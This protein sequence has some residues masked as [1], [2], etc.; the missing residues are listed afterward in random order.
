MKDKFNW[1]ENSSADE[2]ENILLSA[3]NVKEV[4]IASA[5][6]S[7]KGVEIIK[8]LV[9]KHKLGKVMVTVCIS[10]EFSDDKPADL[11]TNLSDFASV[12]ISKDRVF[13]PKVYYIKSDT[14]PLLLFGSS[15]FTNGGFNLNIEFNK[16]C[17][18]T[19][20]EI[21]EL[22]LF[23]K[24]CRNQTTAVTQEIIDFY[25]AQETELSEIRNARRKISAKLKNLG[26]NKQQVNFDKESLLE[27]EFKFEDYE[28]FFLENQEKD[29]SALSKQRENVQEKL[30]NIHASVMP[31]VVDLKLV[32][33]W[34]KKNITSL[35]LRNKF[36]NYKLS[37]MGV[38][39]FDEKA[40]D[41]IKFLHDSSHKDDYNVAITKAACLQYNISSSGFQIILFF[42]QHNTALEDS[43][44]RYSLYL[45]FS[46]KAQG[47]DNSLKLLKGKGF[48][49]I[50]SKQGEEDKVFDVDT[51]NDLAKFLEENDKVGYD[52][53]LIKSYSPTDSL[54]KTKEDIVNEII[55]Q[56]KRIQPLYNAVRR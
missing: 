2:L 1:N 43:F 19:D 6:L 44:D 40:R 31:K 7:K 28:T 47:I 55:E 29:S 30:L 24:F 14:K 46:K 49:W 23:E 42:A 25:K 41:D 12:R 54:I 27:H 20:K 5:F 35:S 22:E 16:I 52:S 3:E 26:K 53:Y 45:E 4:F 15:N 50:I 13:H 33:H 51:R 56:F 36:N 10:A 48:K 9:G 17:V 34:S 11:L 8:K 32:P 21:Q 18:P 37:W 38:R 39:Y